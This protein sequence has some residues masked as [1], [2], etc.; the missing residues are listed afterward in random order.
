M[1]YILDALRKSESERHQGKVPDLG[2]QLQLIHRPPKRHWPIQVLLAAGLLLNAGVLAYVFWPDQDDPVANLMSAPEQAPTAASVNPVA[3]TAAQNSAAVDVN[4][5]PPPL[6]V[7]SAFPSE[8]QSPTVIVPSG[9]GNSGAVDGNRNNQGWD[10]I[11]PPVPSGAEVSASSA[12]GVRVPHLV[13]L[14][15]SF[16]RSVPDLMVNSHIFASVPQ[17][18]RV[19]IN[20]QNLRPGD[21]FQGLRVEEI[22]ED[23]VVLSRQGQQFRLGIVRDW[24]SPR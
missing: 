11:G 15:L 5:A 19:M 7:Q 10:Q 12:D 8:F 2:R 16:Q 17:A 20:N 1:S 14:P 9:Y 22:T 4:P 23:G 13:E 18:R 24:M 3:A 21:S 6:D